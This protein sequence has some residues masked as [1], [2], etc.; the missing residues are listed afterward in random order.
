MTNKTS[1][2][3]QHA[4]AFSQVNAWV[5]LKNGEQVGTVTI[6]Y[7]KDG[8]GRLWAYVHIIGLEMARDFASGYGYDKRSAAVDHAIRNIEPVSGIDKAMKHQPWW[9]EWAAKVNGTASQWKE[10]FK[11]MGGQDWEQVLRNAGFTVIKAV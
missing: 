2:Y 6:K 11:D 8:A 7:P 5:V 3:D 1:I 9:I 10:I 4:K